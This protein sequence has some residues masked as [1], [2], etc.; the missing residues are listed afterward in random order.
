MIKS[1]SC[2]VQDSAETGW[3]GRQGDPLPQ[4]GPTASAG[5]QSWHPPP[6]PGSEM[7]SST[8]NSVGRGG[9]WP[10]PLWLA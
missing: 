8:L 7:P 10:F 4:G 2:L 1:D 6:L 5:P 9:A 3:P